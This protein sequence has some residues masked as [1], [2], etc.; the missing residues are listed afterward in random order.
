MTFL[1]DTCV[2][3]ELVAKQP[4]LHVVQWVDSIDEDKLFLSAITIG[5]IKR[6]IEKLADSSRKSA[7]A[8]WLEGDLLIR[9]TDRILPIDVPVMLVWGQLTADLEKQGRR[10]SAIDSLI[11]ATCLQAR[12]DLVTC[13]ERDF[14]HSGITVVNPWE[15]Q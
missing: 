10:M 4:N 11:A 5:E 3:S 9:F 8:E 12:L 6:G 14:A 13:N 1:L 2:I 7:L 15:Q